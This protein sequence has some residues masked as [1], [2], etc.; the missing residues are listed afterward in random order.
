ML[1]MGGRGLDV[2]VGC[3]TAGCGET[4]ALST[5]TFRGIPAEGTCQRC[6]AHLSLAGGRLSV[7]PPMTGW[8]RPR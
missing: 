1:R 8:A 6:G 4:V 3:P 7:E 2:L 5:H